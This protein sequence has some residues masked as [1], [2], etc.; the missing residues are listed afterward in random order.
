MTNQ[1]DNFYYN[2]DDPVQRE[3]NTLTDE[4]IQDFISLLNDLS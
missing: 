2:K 4:N 3:C 1:P